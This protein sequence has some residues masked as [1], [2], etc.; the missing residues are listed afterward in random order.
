MKSILL[1]DTFNN[2]VDVYDKARPTYPQELLED[3]L[4]FANLSFF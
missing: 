4:K 1:K 2:V 3:V